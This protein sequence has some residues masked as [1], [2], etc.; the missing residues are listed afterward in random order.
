[1]RRIGL[2][3]DQQQMACYLE[4]FGDKNIRFYQSL[5]YE[6]VCNIEIVDETEV[7]SM[8]GVAIVR[9]TRPKDQATV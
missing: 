7:S 4:M 6:I 9:Q 5:G 8:A 1:M 2:I 3:A